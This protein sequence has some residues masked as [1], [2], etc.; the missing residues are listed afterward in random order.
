MYSLNDPEIIGDAID[1]TRH[2]LADCDCGCTD[3][4]K[5]KQPSDYQSAIRHWLK[6][7]N[8]SATVIATAGSGKTTTLEMLAYDLPGAA[9]AVFLAFSKAIATELSERLPFP[10]STFHSFCFKAV[11]SFLK[12]KTRIWPKPD[13]NKTHTLIDARYGESIDDIRSAVVRLVGLVKNENGDQNVTDETIISLMDRHEIEWESSE[14]TYLDV[15]DIT[16]QLLADS[17]TSLAIV[18]FDDMLWMVERFNLKLSK[19]AYVMVDEAQDTNPL[20]RAILKRIMAPTSRLIAV[21]DHAQ[22]IYG[23]RGASNDA[24]GII[25]REFACV[26]LPLT[27][28]YRCARSIVQLASRYGHI[29]AS[30]T[31]IEGTILSP[32]SVS[33]TSFAPGDMV[34]CRN[35]APLVQL[36][37]KLIARRIPAII[38]G[39]DIGAGLTSLVKRLA[40]KRG[41]LDTL[42]ER[43]AEY[44]SAEVSKALARRQESKAQSI[45][46]KCESVMALLDTM[47]DDDRADG[48]AGLIRVI[49]SL[50]TDQN[51]SSRVLLS[52]IHKSKGLERDNVLIL[53]WHL[54]PSP[55]ARQEWQQHQERNLQFVAITRAKSRLTFVSSETLQD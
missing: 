42:A 21:G 41:T 22:A 5:G 29:E 53:D 35:T 19:F 32:E 26:E 52:T 33:L 15:C 28:S 31:A 25:S 17:L 55:M 2:L 1:A 40:G 24:L 45:S 43:L 8:G 27:V 9:Q 37:Y 44:Q 14:F 16:R 39:R 46:D 38:K 36:A 54:C 50:F 47:T 20:Q 3:S 18:D 7:G 11:G 12:Q 13:G 30:P 10:A 4:Y 34:L 6:N 51:D 23:F 49:E 48:I